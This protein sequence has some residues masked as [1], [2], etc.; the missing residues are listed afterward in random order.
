MTR[1]FQTPIRDRGPRLSDRE[2]LAAYRRG[3]RRAAERLVDRTYAAIYAALIRLCGDRQ[4]AEDLTQETYRKAWQSLSTF[5]GRSRVTTWLYRIA[6][7]TF[8]NHLRRDSRTLP[9][10]ERAAAAVE[11]PRPTPGERLEA[12]LAATATRR[13]VLSLPEPLRFVVAARYWG[14][15][16]VREIARQEGITVVAVRKRLK[17]A[18]A[19]L[20][21][22][23]EESNR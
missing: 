18:L 7:T 16:P 6:Y 13:A 2:L 17:K 21:D 11:D 19:M 3:D 14:D 12:S 4:R 9:L 1:T 5:E 15:L 23:L 22:L 10:D 20:A 8:L